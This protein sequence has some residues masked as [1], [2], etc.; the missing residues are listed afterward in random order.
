MINFQTTTCSIGFL[1][2]KLSSDSHLLP[3]MIPFLYCSL[4]KI[5]NLSSLV[6]LWFS[7]E[8]T[9]I[10]LFFPLLLLKVLIKYICQK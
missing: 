5:A 8:L 10:M 4:S 3:T 9:Q 6:H 7:L 1:K 2:Q